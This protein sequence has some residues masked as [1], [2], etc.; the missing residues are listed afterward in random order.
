MAKKL[1]IVVVAILV[2][3]VAILFFVD[4]DSPE[5]GNAV[6]EKANEATGANLS[7]ESFRLNLIRG[8]ELEGVESTSSFPGTVVNVRNRQIGVE[9]PPAPIVVRTGGSGSGPFQTP[10]S[11]AGRTG[12]EKQEELW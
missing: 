8:L 1:F 4:F 2:V 10:R 12:C 7:V 9:T 3:A 11:G 5:L 6:L